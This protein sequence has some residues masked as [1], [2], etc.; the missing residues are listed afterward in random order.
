MLNWKNGSAIT[1]TELG[2][3]GGLLPRST[4]YVE[5]EFACLSG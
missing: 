2:V 5:F 1:P 3:I 4:P